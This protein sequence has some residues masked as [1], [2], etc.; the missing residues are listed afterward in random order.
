MKH[1]EFIGGPLDG[2]KVPAT[3]YFKEGDWEAIDTLSLVAPWNGWSAES[4]YVTI[5]DK[6]IYNSELTKK[7]A[8][9][10]AADPT[11]L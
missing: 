1:I 5:G 9:V 3:E 2:I 11:Q 10:T 7:R 6:L 4:V 8:E